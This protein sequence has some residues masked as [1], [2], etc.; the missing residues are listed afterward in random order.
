MKGQL[1]KWMAVLFLV[2]LASFMTACANQFLVEDMVQEEEPEQNPGE[3]LIVVGVSQVGSESIWRTAHTASIQE[4]LTTE[5]GYYMIFDNARQKQE[6]QIKAIRNFISQ[7]VDYI[8][9]SPITETGW[10]TVLSE[11]KDAGIPVILMD[12]M[13]DVEDDSLYT[14]WIGSDFEA[15]GKNAGY[16]LEEYLEKKEMTGKDINIVVLQGTEGSTSVIGRTKGFESI[17]K[18]N[19]NW[20]IIEQVDA[21]FTTAKGYEVM[22]YFLEEY[23]DIDVV[24]SQNDD[25]TFGALEAME[26]AG[27]STGKDGDVIIISFDAVKAALEKV[28]DGEIN[29]DIECNPLQG[30]YIDRIIRDLE[31]G[32]LD[33]KMYY[34][35]ERVFTPENVG[36]VIDDR[37]Y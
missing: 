7:D 18:K 14:A 24:V 22:Q 9:L 13:V 28:K 16:W 34:T 25:M 36:L 32:R 37:T 23:E 1:K 3:G 30:Q 29:V 27:I 19:R 5:N 4:T 33:E 8:V 6:N 10:D 20:H 12:R 31:K 26:E 2:I 21:D 17:A 11:A 15:E 35:V